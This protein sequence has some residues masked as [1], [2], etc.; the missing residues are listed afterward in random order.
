MSR[1]GRITIIFLIILLGIA[2]IYLIWPKT[3]DAKP[4]TA[5]GSVSLPKVEITT[6]VSVEQAIQ[7]RRSIRRYTNQ[8]LSLQD[9]SQLMWAAQGIT[10]PETKFRTVPSGGRTFPLEVYII[11]GKNSVNGLDEGLYHYIPQNHS[12]EKLLNGDLREQFAKLSNSQM[13]IKNAPV[14]III[15][16]NYGKMID[17]YKDEKLSIRF[18]DME[19]GHA[20]QNIYLEAEARNLATV[21]IGSFY[22]EQAEDF[23]NLPPDESILYSYPVGHPAKS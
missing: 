8:S 12:L 4:R 11:V 1:N 13:W 20:G 5:I 18:V 7:N 17:K 14:N 6:N 19:A 9:I 16:G 23:L 10:D 15:A 3:E 21:A 2:F 22:E